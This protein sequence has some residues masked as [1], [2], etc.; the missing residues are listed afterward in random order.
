MGWHP[1][2]MDS[3]FLFL[4]AFPPKQVLSLPSL[5][6][7]CL[8]PHLLWTSQA[9]WTFFLDEFFGTEEIQLQ[10]HMCKGLYWEI[11]YFFILRDQ[12]GKIKIQVSKCSL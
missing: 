5:P 12:E 11:F 2:V 10:S 9:Y 8:H 1:L 3:V 6:P 4:F 7:P